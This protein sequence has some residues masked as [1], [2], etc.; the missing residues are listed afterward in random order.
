SVSSTVLIWKRLLCRNQR[1]RCAFWILWGSGCGGIAAAGI[2]HGLGEG[3][4]GFARTIDR[5]DLRR[6]VEAHALGRHQGSAD[7]HACRSSDFALFSASWRHPILKKRNSSP[8]LRPVT[9]G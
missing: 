7:L 3:E 2:D 4:Q 5:Q 9:R 8:Q 1:L 6:G